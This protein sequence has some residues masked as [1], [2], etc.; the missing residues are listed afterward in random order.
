MIP[1]EE[2]E[3]IIE[4]AVERALL[5]LPD[6][7]NRLLSSGIVMKKLN[8]EFYEK[9]PEFDMHRNVVASVVEKIEGKNPTDDYATILKKA[10]PKIE[11]RLEDIKELDFTT[12]PKPKLDFHGEI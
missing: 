5:R 1:K 8:T 4:E 6:V 12:L 3:G 9:Y 11:E 10:V 7:M 2:R